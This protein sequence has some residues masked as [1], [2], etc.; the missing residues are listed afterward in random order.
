MPNENSLAKIKVKRLYR[1]PSGNVVRVVRVDWRKNSVIVHNYH[2]HSNEYFEYSEISKIFEPLFS[3]T[4][5]AKI[6]GK[7]SSTI[8]KYESI[9]LIPEARK[10]SLNIEG[11]ALTRVYTSK[12][13]EDL[14]L[15]FQNRRPVGRPSSTNISGFNKDAVRKKIRA[16]LDKEKNN[17]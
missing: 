7:K 13:I 8:R 5:V 1:L 10:I 17:G 16:V 14:S 4:E 2:S 12:D 6:L 9:G 3:I 15:F 11:K